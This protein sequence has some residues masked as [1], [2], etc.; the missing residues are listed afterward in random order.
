VLHFIGH[1]AFD[2]GLAEGF[3]LF[4]DEEG[5]QRRVSGEELGTI[6]SSRRISLAVLNACEGARHAEADAFAGVAQTLVQREIPA[7]VAMQTEITDRAAISFSGH[8]Y[9]LLAEGF[10]VDGAVSEARKAMYAA[11]HTVEWG[12]PVLYMRSADG[13]L[14]ASPGEPRHRRRWR[15]IVDPLRSPRVWLPIVLLV[16]V[17]YA[18]TGPL[19]KEARSVALPSPVV[20]M[21]PRG[22]PPSPSSRPAPET[23][24][25]PSSSTRSRKADREK[26][27]AW[28]KS[29]PECP[30]PPG[31]DLR[32]ALIP[33]GSFLMGSNKKDEKPSHLV[34]ITKPFCLGQS[35]VTWRQWSQVMGGK[36]NPPKQTGDELPVTKVSWDQAQ[37][38]VTKLNEVAGRPRFR[39]AT[40]AEW[41]YAARASTIT[42]Y[43]FGD[44]PAELRQY[45]NCKGGQ[46]MPVHQLQ[47]NPWGLYDMHGNVWEWVEDWYGEYSAAPAVDPTGPVEGDKRVRRG[48]S[49]ESSFD[50]CRSAARKSW[51]P[52]KG[53]RDLGFRIV[54]VLN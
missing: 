31:T 38:F 50:N 47:P 6:L 54:E 44:E 39:L 22:G 45:G 4:A 7:V 26:S 14:L 10:P 23:P 24:R 27:P 8:F 18:L 20:H 3:L 40:E 37:Q 5:R 29:A 11:G 25:P 46:A 30:S 2:R 9:Q 52:G 41:E 28:G 32:F 16:A 15:G 49:F 48:G 36:P 12:T 53:A 19:K 1:G 42:P 35:E 13:H 34:T 17:G 33:K 43:S 21:E 51:D